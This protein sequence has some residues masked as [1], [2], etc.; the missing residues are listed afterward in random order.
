MEGLLP[1]KKAEE[2]PSG[3]AMP[4][5]EKADAHEYRSDGAR[6]DRCADDP[7]SARMALMHGMMMGGMMGAPIA[8]LA[9][10]LILIAI[11]TAVVILAVGRK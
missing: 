7:R 3:M 10:L 6:R 1:K 5:S 4:K 8:T 11:I 9:G 2:I